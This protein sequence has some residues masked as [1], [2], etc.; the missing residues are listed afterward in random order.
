MKILFR[1]FVFFTLTWGLVHIGVPALPGSVDDYLIH[2]ALTETPRHSSQNHLLKSSISTFHHVP[3]IKLIIPALKKTILLASTSFLLS[4]TFSF[5]MLYGAFR[6]HKIYKFLQYQ[7]LLFSTF[8]LMILG[9]LLLYFLSVQWMIFPVLNN[10]GLAALSLSL[11]MSH[12]WFRAFSKIIH[13]F[14]P[15][16]SEIGYRSRG[17]SELSIFI[18]CLVFPLNSNFYAYL[19][20]QL[21]NLLAGSV[22]VELVFQWN[23]M[24]LLLLQSLQRRDLPVIESSILLIALLSLS[25]NLLFS[26]L[27]YFNR[28][29]S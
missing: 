10:V 28:T 12:T 8:P 7:S 14:R 23:G 5:L 21:G 17:Y 9:P 25:A 6:S 15:Q 18:R 2:D 16:S 26:N 24:G 22:V 11:V 13:D 20:H 3:V 19:G 29:S 4:L 1:T 27:H